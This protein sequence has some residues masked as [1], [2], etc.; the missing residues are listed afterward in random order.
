MVIEAR[1][2]QL[3]KPQHEWKLGRESQKV[4]SK[5]EKNRSERVVQ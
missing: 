1:R 5:S 4:M 3:E 2:R